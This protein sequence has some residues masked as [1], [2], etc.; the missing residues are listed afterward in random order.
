MSV[1]DAAGVG[2][3]FDH[4]LY[5]FSVLSAHRYCWINVTLNASRVESLFRNR[6]LWKFNYSIA[7]NG[8]ANCIY[9]K[10]SQT[11]ANRSAS[12]RVRL[13]CGMWFLPFLRR[14]E[15]CQAT[16][17]H[18]WY[19]ATWYSVRIGNFACRSRPVLASKCGWE[20]EQRNNKLIEF[21][22]LQL[23]IMGTDDWNCSSLPIRVERLQWWTST[24]VHLNADKCRRWRFANRPL[25]MRSRSHIDRW[26]HVPNHHQHNEISNGSHKRRA[27]KRTHK[28]IDTH[29]HFGQ[30]EPI[31]NIAF[32]WPILGLVV[33]SLQFA[34]IVEFNWCIRRTIDAFADH[35]VGLIWNEQNERWNFYFLWFM[36]ESGG[37]KWKCELIRICANEIV[38]HATQHS[39]RTANCMR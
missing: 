19:A 9:I 37:G 39:P 7:N 18:T 29:H 13:A 34:R 4:K 31:R 5:R 33:D 38:S 8:S 14:I 28:C 36:T 32:E 30:N 17:C 15:R 24:P 11:N 6:L 12:L 23:P 20:G 21:G 25:R 16:I 35:F 10:R 2:D 1:C 22:R 26:W 27:I 3:Q